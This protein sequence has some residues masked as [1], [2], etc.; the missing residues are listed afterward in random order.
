MTQNEKVPQGQAKIELETLRAT[1]T[2]Y[3][4]NGE[5]INDRLMAG[6]VLQHWDQIQGDLQSSLQDQ[7]SA[8]L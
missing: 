8:G 4:R 5:L 2:N 3:L 7:Q 6:Y 1:L